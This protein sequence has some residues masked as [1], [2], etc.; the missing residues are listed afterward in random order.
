MRQDVTA[1]GGLSRQ[2][3]Q[4]AGGRESRDADNRVVAPVR[5]GRALHPF[6]P[7]REDRAVEGGREL[8]GASEETLRPHDAR[9]GLEQAKT[10][11]RFHPRDHLAQRRAR[12]QAIGIQRHGV[13]IGPAGTPYEILDISRLA[14]P[15]VASVAVEDAARPLRFRDQHAERRLLGG[16]SVLRPGIG[17]DHDIQIERRIA[18]RPVH[19]GDPCEGGDRVFVADRDEHGG[20]RRRGERGRGPRPARPQAHQRQRRTPGEPAGRDED[21][22]AADRVPDLEPVLQRRIRHQHRRGHG[23]EHRKAKGHGA[24]PDRCRVRREMGS[25]C[26]GKTSFRCAGA[27]GSS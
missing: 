2:F 18:D 27:E 12:H 24:Q 17:Q 7:A 8:H 25:G 15:V 10:R 20:A 11:V 21:Q 13:V 1:E 14:A 22:T 16:L 4:T 9:Q 6:Q 3:W 5:P 19:G 26:H 23:R